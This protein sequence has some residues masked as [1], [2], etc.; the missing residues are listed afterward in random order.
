[1]NN[2]EKMVY[3]GIFMAIGMVLPFFT[4]GIPAIGQMLLPMH[5]S[6][7]LCTFI[8]GWDYALIL[9]LL[10]PIIRSF[11]FSMPPFNIAFAMMPELA[12]YALVTGK[13]YEKFEKKNLA[14]IYKSM[15]PGMIAGKIVWGIANAVLTGL[16]A[17]SFTFYMF[18]TTAFI[19]AIP[20]IILQ[21]VLI[22]IIVVI[23]NKNSD[24]FKEESA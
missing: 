17:K 23:F 4:A 18:I 21:L 19:S 11:I 1:M 5:I 15:I 9:G 14:A 3:T 6:V 24:V 8:C 20:G 22:P 2:T 13:L 12:I 10:L 16:E 7:F